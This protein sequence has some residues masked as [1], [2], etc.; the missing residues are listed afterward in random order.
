MSAEPVGPLP[1]LFIVADGMGGHN[2]GAIASRQAVDVFCSYVRAYAEGG[3]A[4]GESPTG[5]SSAI[6]SQLDLMMDAVTAANRRV[7][8]ASL[9]DPALKGMGTTLTACTVHDGK[10]EIVHIGDSRAYMVTPGQIKQLTTDHSFV[11]EMVKAGKLTPKEA[12][13]H[14]QKN[15]LTRALGIDSDMSADGYICNLDER[16]VLLLCSDGLTN[17][18]SDAVLRAEALKHTAVAG[19]VDALVKKANRNGGMDNISLII[20]DTN[21]TDRAG[22]R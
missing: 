9:S 4:A 13:A 19:R 18:V 12:L 17:M 10:C 14:P 11:N 16:C 2:G 3:S 5:V 20:I 15:I 21:T 1:N 22:E 6:G 7:H 8:E